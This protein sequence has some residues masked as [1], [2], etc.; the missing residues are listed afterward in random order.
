[1]A[2]KEPNLEAVEIDVRVL[3]SDG[4]RGGISVRNIQAARKAVALARRV[5][6]K[7]ARIH[8][9]GLVD[10]QH[11]IDVKGWPCKCQEEQQG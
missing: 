11:T 5:S 9:A 6:R 4:D 1:L 3:A 8:C 2:S 10:L 7:A